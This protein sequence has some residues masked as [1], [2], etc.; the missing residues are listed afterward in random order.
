M[1]REAGQL[2]GTVF[3]IRFIFQSS[4]QLRET[5]RANASSLPNQP[6][7]CLGP[8]S[9]TVVGSLWPT[10]CHGAFPGHTQVQVLVILGLGFTP[11]DA[12]YCVWD[13]ETCPSFPYSLYPQLISPTL[14]CQMLGTL[15]SQRG[16]HFAAA[17]A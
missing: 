3:F 13:V 14:E 4:L 12:L 10:C 16:P 7:H 1:L 6:S 15:R 5:V 8:A 2:S 9:R 11:G 17:T